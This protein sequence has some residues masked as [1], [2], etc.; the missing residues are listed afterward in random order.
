MTDSRLNITQSL[1]DAEKWLRLVDNGDGT[2]SIATGVPGA[3]VNVACDS[4]VVNY[5]DATKAT[6]STIVYKYGGATVLTLTLTEAATSD[7]WT[8]A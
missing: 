7:T 3:L 6:I 2:Y 1:D 4:I 5:T 8:R